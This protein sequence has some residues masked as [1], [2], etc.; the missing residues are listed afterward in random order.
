MPDAAE[1]LARADAARDARDWAVAAAHYADYLRERPDDRGAIVQRGHMVKEAGDPG[2]ALA[3][4]AQ[5][6]AMQPEDPDIHLQSGHALK[7]LGRLPEALAAYARAARLD[8]EAEDP[9]REW[10]TLSTRVPAGPARRVTGTALDLSDL[11]SWVLG[12]HRAPSGIQRVQYEIAAALLADPAA[13]PV[14]LCAMRPGEGGWREIPTPLLHRLRRLAA[15][16]ADPADPDWAQAVAVLHAA[17][18]GAPD[19]TLSAGALLFC[20]GTAWA[21]PQ[22]AARLAAAR[23]AGL[24]YVPLLHDTI[25][26]SVPE[27]CSAGTVEDYARWFSALPMLADGVVCN[28]AATEAGLREAAARFLPGLPLPPTRVV[29]LDGLPP[30][31]PVPAELPPALGDGRPFALCVGTIEGR[32]NHALVFQ[33]WLTL[34]RRL[35][36]NCPRLVCVGRPGWR[37]EGALSLLAASPELAERVLILHEVDDAALRALTRHCLFSICA[38]HAE[39]WGLP[40]SEALALRRPVL[41]AG[42]SALIESGAGGATFFAPNSE[43]DFVEKALLLLADP[44]A[45]AARIAPNGGCRPWAAVAAE[46]LAAATALAEAAPAPAPPVLPPGRRVRLARRVLRQPGAEAALAES[47]PR[48]EGWA[49]A[50]ASGRDA[51]PGSA[52]ILARVPD[53]PLRLVLELQAAEPPCDLRISAWRDGAEE[54][55]AELLLDTAAPTEAVLPLPEGGERLEITLDSD[56]GVTVLALGLARLAS[57]EDRLKLLEARELLAVLPPD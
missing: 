28:S 16:G 17:L 30:A 45:V 48:G 38:S 46:M 7:L 19:L 8:P 11:A 6:E 25:P 41:A 24:R 23:D 26:I 2:A 12:R 27:W 31:L 40:V 36:A 32:K 15:T 1:L 53:G 52:A 35:G 51:R 54:A 18:E 37:A 47:L 56:S 57:V 14:T 43:P 33:A 34:L 44:E 10:A 9:W 21:L 29:R 42:H 13:G 20:P 50:A 3:L 5:A 55:S 4:Y 22:Y 39:G 49:T